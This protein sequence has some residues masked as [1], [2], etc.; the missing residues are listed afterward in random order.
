LG[1]NI[2]P[3]VHAKNRSSL[4]FLRVCEVKVQTAKELFKAVQSNSEP[5]KLPYTQAMALSNLEQKNI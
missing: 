5:A 1:G 2:Y 4:A 3:Y